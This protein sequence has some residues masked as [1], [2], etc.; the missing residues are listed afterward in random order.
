VLKQFTWGAVVE[1][2]LDAYRDVP[3]HEPVAVAV[4]R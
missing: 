4:S 1:R 2:C 3:T